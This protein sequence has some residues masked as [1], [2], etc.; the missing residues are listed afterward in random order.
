MM[1]PNRRLRQRPAASM[2]DTQP[3]QPGGKQQ[4]SI[5]DR[6]KKIR[7]G[8]VYCIGFMLC[9][10]SFHLILPDGEAE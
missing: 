8:T 7:L 3:Q 5:L 9:N 4:K 6:K 1:Q 2:F 10:R